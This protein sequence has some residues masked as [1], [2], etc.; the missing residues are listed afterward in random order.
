MISDVS[1]C[2]PPCSLYAIVGQSGCGKSTLAK[3]LLG[4]CAPQEGMITIGG[5]DVAKVRRD[6]LS[7][8]ISGVLQDPR[9][10]IFPYAKT[11]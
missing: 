10:S 8:T 4:I 11:C 2:I 3:L 5:Q 7:K 6:A 9:S 1:L